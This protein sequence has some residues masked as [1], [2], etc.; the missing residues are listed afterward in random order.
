MFGWWSRLSIRW[1]LQFTFFA[2]TMA[3]TLYNR[4]IEMLNLQ[5]ML[6]LAEREGVTEETMAVLHQH[7]DDVMVTAIWES[8][9]E[10]LVQFVLIAILAAVMVRP[11]MAL[12]RSLRSVEKGDLTKP[13]EVT[14]Q[15]E[16]GQVQRQFNDMLSRLN[17]LIASIH[18]SSVHMGQSAY[19]IAAVSREIEQISRAQE[20]R[21]TEVTEATDALHQASEQV[22]DLSGNT[23]EKA[24]ETEARGREG[25]ESVQQTIQRMQVIGQGVG[26]ASS[27][28]GE[29]QAAAGTIG[30]IVGTIRSISEQTNLLALNAAIEAA[31]AGDSGR[32]FAVVADEVRALAA[33]TGQS[34]EE[35]ARIVETLIQ[36]VEAV[37]RVMDGVVADM[38]ENRESSERTIGIIEAMGNDISETTELNQRIS[39]ASSEQLE[40]L[41]QVND[42]LSTLFSTLQENS[43][44]IGNTANIGDA[45]FEL[46]SRLQNQLTGMKY[47]ESHR[48]RSDAPSNGE[49]RRNAERV[50]GH[51]LVTIWHNSTQYEGLSQDISL[52]G[53]NLL[54]KQSFEQGSHLRLQIQMPSDDIRD[55]SRHDIVE[56]EG[57]VVWRRDQ[58]NRYRYGIKFAEQSA[59]KRQQLEQCVAFF[60]QERRVA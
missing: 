20:T 4:F 10:F 31:R 14:S 8:A 7:Y 25:V 43:Q 53:L 21:S 23:L 40:G 35:V 44:K 47:D 6:A 51:L 3:T 37:S 26:K 34:A 15:D 32:G 27:E 1:K 12:N 57:E 45:L 56:V 41:A 29:L 36:R 59:A 38:D 60:S 46:T 28:V 24:L 42:T 39:Q 58:D 33:R 5:S 2:V 52:T 22:R 48:E 17:R 54:A 30:E 50:S 55:F 16:I 49:E 19:Q 9:L 13:V 18:D 11:I